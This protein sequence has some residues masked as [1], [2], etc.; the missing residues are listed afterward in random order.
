ML[1]M[2]KILAH[3]LSDTVSGRAV[4]YSST[5]CSELRPVNYQC[6]PSEVAHLA[7]RQGALDIQLRLGAGHCESI[8][9]GTGE[10]VTKTPLAPVVAAKGARYT[11]YYSQ[12]HPRE[13]N[14]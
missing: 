2:Q 14:S 3:I 10:I 8:R 12:S 9:S 7:I 11:G 4:I 5:K 1:E 13:L 6:A